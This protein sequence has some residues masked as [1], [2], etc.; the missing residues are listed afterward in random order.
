VFVRGFGNGGAIPIDDMVAIFAKVEPK[1]SYRPLFKRQPKSDSLTVDI[2]SEL[3][4]DFQWQTSNEPNKNDS[5]KNIDG[6]TSKTLD[7]TNL[8]KGAFVRCIAHSEAGAMASN[9]TV[10]T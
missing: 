1:T 8:P 6:A 3:D 9:P 7:R 10:L 5:W 2:S 4:P